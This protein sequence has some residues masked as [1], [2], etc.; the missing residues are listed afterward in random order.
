MN[1]ELRKGEQDEF[2]GAEELASLIL[3]VYKMGKGDNA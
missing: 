2:Y 1:D 3:R